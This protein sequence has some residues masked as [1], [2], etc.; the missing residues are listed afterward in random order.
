MTIFRLSP[1]FFF[2]VAYK[3]SGGIFSVCG[4]TVYARLLA[5]FVEKVCDF[6]TFL[7][8]GGFNGVS[9]GLSLYTSS[10]HAQK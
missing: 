2:C 1:G 4:K 9:F 5:L 3:D 6:W 10:K 7:L 8:T